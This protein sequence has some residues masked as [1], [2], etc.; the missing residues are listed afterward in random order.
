M[1]FFI[2]VKGLKYLDCWIALTVFIT[3][4]SDKYLSYKTL[5]QF[6]SEDKQTRLFK[7]ELLGCPSFKMGP[8]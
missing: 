1:C 3:S 5:Y 8:F 4:C 7:P 2:K 6:K